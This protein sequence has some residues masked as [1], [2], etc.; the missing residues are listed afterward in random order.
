MVTIT[1]SRCQPSLSESETVGLVGFLL[2]IPETN[3]VVSEEYPQR[4]DAMILKVLGLVSCSVIVHAVVKEEPLAVPALSGHPGTGEPSAYRK[5]KVALVWSVAVT[6][7]VLEVAQT[8]LSGCTVFP[9]MTGAVTSN[10]DTENGKLPLL[11]PFA[12]FARI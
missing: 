11:Y 9:A 12:F 1:S 10:M 3:T 4:S 2:S 5:E 8:L 6:V 7:S